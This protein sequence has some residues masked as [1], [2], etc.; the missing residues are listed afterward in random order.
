[1]TQVFR[2]IERICDGIRAW[3]GNEQEILET[4]IERTITEGLFPRHDVMHMVEQVRRTVT[5]PAMT[6]WWKRE[7]GEQKHAENGRKVLCLHAGNLPMVGLQDVI[8]VLLSG[9][10]YYGKLSRKD[11]WLL[12]GLLR[13]LRERM[14][15]QFG[16]HAVR[17]EDLP[18]AEAEDVLFAGSQA[19]VKT[20]QDRIHK[21]RLARPDARF[22]PRTARLSMA[23][24]D[25]SQSGTEAMYSDL[26]E[27]M[28]RYEG[29]GCRSVAV[30]VSDSPLRD[31][32]VPL[33]NAAGAFLRNHPTAGEPLPVVVWWRSYLKSLGKEVYDVGS[34]IMVDDPEMMGREG[35]ICWI[36]GDEYE[37]IRLARRFGSQL[38]SVYIPEEAGYPGALSGV[39]GIR[40]EPLK[41]AQSPPI[42]WQ[43]DG[44]D[45]LSWLV[46]RP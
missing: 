35:V 42:D 4:S 11:P 8:A 5:E 22:L 31:V 39:G 19:S 13:L 38:Q 32:I 3:L 6:Q 25:R 17:M 44:I 14:P 15:E 27:A 9:G 45:V 43:P 18:P 7:I 24:I 41:D 2:R 26:A 12:G 34:Q 1:M 46:Q 40:L 21:L 23:W 10:V 28:L 29:S 36:K 30:V 33:T 16:N 37:V 20:V